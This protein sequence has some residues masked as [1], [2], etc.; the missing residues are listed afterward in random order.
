MDA[1]AAETQR[2]YRADL[3]AFGTWMDEQGHQETPEAAEQYLSNWQAETWKASTRARKRTVV[4]KFYEWAAKQ[5]YRGTAFVTHLSSTQAPRLKPL[6]PA[7]E[8]GYQAVIQ[9]IPDDR[10]RDHLLFRLLGEGGLRLGEI[11]GLKVSDLSREMGQVTLRV[12][13]RKRKVSLNTDLST[14]LLQYLETAQ[15]TEGP[16]FVA[17]WNGGGSALRQSWIYVLWSS[18]AKPLGVQISPGQLYQLKLIRAAQSGQLSDLKHLSP[19][20][21]RRIKQRTKLE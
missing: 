11:Q 4:R 19:R 16:L 14:L 17:R 5:G 10:I 2:A 7:I 20:S 12:G 18:Y 8:T 13:T 6:S 21:R 1:K 3:M 15:I 9:S